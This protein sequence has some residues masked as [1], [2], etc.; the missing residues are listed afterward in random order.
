[1]SQHVTFVYNDPE[2]LGQTVFIKRGPHQGKL[3]IVKRVTEQ[4]RF[5][6]TGGDFG[7]AF[8]L[9]SRKEFIVYRHRKLRMRADKVR[10]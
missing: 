8:V 6:V 4:E 7:K 2:I 3:G 5:E 9:F 10:V 1:M